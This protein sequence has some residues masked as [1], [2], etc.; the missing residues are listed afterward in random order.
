ML[1]H[2]LSFLFFLFPLLNGQI[3]ETDSILDVIPHIDQQ[4]WFLVNLDNTLFESKQALGHAHWFYDE[5]DRRINKGMTRETAI[6]N[7]YSDWMRAQ[8]LCQVK[9]LEENFVSELI[10]LQE[11]GVVIMG[12][13]HRQP[14]AAKSTFKQIQSLEFSFSMTAP[15]K[16]TFIVAA[17]AP[18]LYKQGILF[19]GDYN[20]EGDVLLSFFSTISSTPK[21]IVFID[22]R[23]KNVEE[24]EKYLASLPI[25]YVGVH[26]TAIEHSN[27]YSKE[28]ADLQHHFLNHILSN[29]AARLLIENGFFPE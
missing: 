6:T 18:T 17:S 3:I 8:A 19:V 16:D 4:T 21:K 13:T 2:A 7:T 28:I 14:C 11:K 25:D 9:L 29:E 20:Q 22:D 12:L 26:Y 27:T 15:S 24:L 1:K 23:R 5:V 10:K